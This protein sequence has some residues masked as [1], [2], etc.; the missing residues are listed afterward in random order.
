MIASIETIAFFWSIYKWINWYCIRFGANFKTFAIRSL[1]SPLPTTLSFA[2]SFSPFSQ[3]LV[4]ILGNDLGLDWAFSAN[5]TL[6]PKP[7]NCWLSFTNFLPIVSKCYH[8]DSCVQ[9]VQDTFLLLYC[10]KCF[11]FC[12]THS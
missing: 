11:V 5:Q 3:I 2:S 9:S 10:H 4:S 1:L 8:C 6:L 7:T 12:S